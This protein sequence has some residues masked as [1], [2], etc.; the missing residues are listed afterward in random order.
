MS[1]LILLGKRFTR[2]ILNHLVSMLIPSSLW[3]VIN[4]DFIVDLPSSKGQIVIMVVADYFTKHTIYVK[5]AIVVA[6]VGARVFLMNVFKY[7]GLLHAIAS[8]HSS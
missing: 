7:Y 1:K 2:P 4:M 6:Q 5:D 3:Q 8:S